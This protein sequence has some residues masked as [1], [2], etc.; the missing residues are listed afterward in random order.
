MGKTET[1][2]LRDF[3]LLVG[4]I[5]AVMGLWPLLIRGEPLRLWAVGIGLTLVGFGLTVPVVLRPLHTAW[6]WIGHVLGWVNTRI[7]LS[8]VFY[9]LITPISIVFRMMG[10][11]TIPHKFA[12]SRSTYRII[13]KPRQRG[14]MR[15]Q[16]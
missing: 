11:E 9:G 5:F 2:P 16:F 6:M 8:V 10:K 15:Y 14:H 7:I 3:G 12:E 1:K 13:R 4:G